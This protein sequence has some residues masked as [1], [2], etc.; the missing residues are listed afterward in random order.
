MFRRFS[1][2]TLASCAVLA[3][4][5]QL[6]LGQD[7]RID[8]DVFLGDEK[9]PCSEALTIFHQGL[10][11]D[12][13]LAQPEE[14]TIYDAQRGRFTLLDPERKRKASVTTQELL[15]FVLQFESHAAQSKNALFAFSAAPKFATAIEELTVNG[16]PQTK[17]SLT[18]K[19]LEYF[20]V[21][22][23]CEHP[24]A[25][26]LYRQFADWTA[27]LNA[28]RHGNLPPGARLALNATLA[29]QQLLPLEVTKII[30][31]ATPLSRKLEMRTQHLVNWSLSGEDRKRI[32]RAGEHLVSL[33][34][35]SFDEYRTAPSAPPASKQARR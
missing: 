18:A 14:I 26:G 5:M 25:V 6:A 34:S 28:T 31:A 22:R 2:A 4:T 15:D 24:E 11:Y 1:L 20:A 12:F 27:R 23:P 10:V 17:I 7:F 21:G 33:R 19:P 16:Q 30:P 35:V 3:L 13:L 8:T 29:D 9:T 32:D